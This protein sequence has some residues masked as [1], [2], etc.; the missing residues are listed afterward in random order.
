MA[1]SCWRCNSRRCWSCGGSL[2]DLFS[3]LA[4]VCD[5]L[6]AAVATAEGYH[7]MLSHVL[8]LATCVAPSQQL[9]P[10]YTLHPLSP[11]IPSPTPS[12]PAPHC[13][14]PLTPL[15]H[16]PHTSFTPPSHLP[17]TPDEEQ[18][19]AA[20][21]RAAAW[22][23]YT[24]T[25]H[26][27]PVTPGATAVATQRP[28]APIKVDPPPAEPFRGVTWSAAARHLPG[29]D[30]RGAPAYRPTVGGTTS[31]RKLLGTAG[32]GIAGPG[33]QAGGGR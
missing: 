30:P 18:Q 7:A 3:L 6:P 28:A 4:T 20:D 27:L 12:F 5:C 1:A 21:A 23:A 31:S 33:L 9:S 11:L 2:S 17:R 29:N 15:S 22:S 24:T 10:F 16:L 19:Q 8:C 25:R 26:H 13:T 14:T 32:G